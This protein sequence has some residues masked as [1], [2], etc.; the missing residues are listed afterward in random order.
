MIREKVTVRIL[1]RDLTLE[2]DGLTQLEMTA[3]ADE[4]TRRMQAIQDQTHIVDTSKLAML[5][6]LELQAELQS[7]GDAA[8]SA[9][10]KAEALAAKLDA[11]LSKVRDPGRE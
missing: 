10:G 9:G 4:V 6:A 8:G 11:A 5:C 7:Q 3:L 2:T 1:G